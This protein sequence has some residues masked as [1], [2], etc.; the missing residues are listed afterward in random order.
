MNNPWLQIPASDYEGHMGSPD[1]GQLQF[2]ARTFQE[3]L[4]KYDAS[5]I[6]LLGCATGNGLEYINSEVTGKLTAIDINPEYLE[7]LRSR[8]G[9]S[10]PGL[11]TV[12]ASLETYSLADSTYS[13][14]YA[15][16]IFEYMDPRVLLPKIAKGLRPGGVIVSVLQLPAKNLAK[17]SKSRYESLKALEPIMKLVSP[18]QFRSTANELGLSEL[19]GKVLTLES[20]KPFYIG[21]Y[22]KT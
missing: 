17:V 6:A 8:Y 3:S 22:G 21:A 10:I 18:S 15:A 19:E 13:L 1:I 7:I 11:E 12:E 9:R 5:A 14:I 2:L 4:I 16:L 20:G